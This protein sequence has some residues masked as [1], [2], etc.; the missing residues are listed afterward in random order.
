[1]THNAESYKAFLSLRSASEHALLS[2]A[3]RSNGWNGLYNAKCAIEEARE[4]IQT[5]EAIL[6]GEEQ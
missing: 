4:A 3:D 6:K 5:L 1:M 2:Y